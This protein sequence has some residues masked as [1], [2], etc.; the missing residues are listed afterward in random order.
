[1]DRL[2]NKLNTTEGKIKKLEDRSEKIVQHIYQ[3]ERDIEGKYENEL[4]KHRKCDR[5]RMFKDI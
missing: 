5:M 1:M 3:R 4:K 2:S